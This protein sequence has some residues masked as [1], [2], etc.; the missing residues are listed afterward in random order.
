MNVSFYRGVNRDITATMRSKEVK[1]S[2]LALIEYSNDHSGRE[3]LIRFLDEAERLTGSRIGFFH[4]VEPN[5]TEL[6]LQVWSTNTTR[7]MCKAEGEGMHYPISKAGVWVDC[8][9]ERKP[10]VHNDYKALTHKKGLPEGHAPIVRELVVPVVRNEEIVAIL[11]VGNKPSL[12]SDQDVETV[13]SMAELTWE[14]YRR[15]EI[16]EAFQKSNEELEAIYK[17]VRTVLFLVDSEGG[18]AKVNQNPT[19]ELKHVENAIL[20]MGPGNFLGCSYTQETGLAC[21]TGVHCP[22]C[23][24]RINILHT[25][26]TK[27]SVSKLPI[28]LHLPEEREQEKSFEKWSLNF[29]PVT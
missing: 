7:H 23:P 2:L 16:E 4:F 9:R 13:Q 1:K 22:M 25:L 29:Q 14:T 27:E 15:K 20:G 11:G 26:K 28:V 21:G 6:K 17:N 5:Q 10:V 3:L 12:Y 24:L 18:V 19:R 8:V